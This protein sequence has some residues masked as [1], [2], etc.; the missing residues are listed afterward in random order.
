ML[1]NA[2]EALILAIW[3]CRGNVVMLVG[4]GGTAVVVSHGWS[5][6]MADRH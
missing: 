3:R 6:G 1:F 2:T 5:T 4:G